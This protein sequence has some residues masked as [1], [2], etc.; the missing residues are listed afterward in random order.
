MRIGVAQTRPVK[1]DIRRNIAG[2][3]A[4]I[5]LAADYGADAIIFP[6]LSLTGYQPQLAKELAI[7]TDDLSLDEFQA[8]S[9]IMNITIGVGIPIRNSRGI[10]ISML[11][12]RPYSGVAVYSKKYLHPDEEPF[13]VPGDAGKPLND[14]KVAI[15]I[16]YELSVPQH[17]VDAVSNGAE[18]YIASVAKSAL[19]VES[20]V[21]ILAGIAN[22]YNMIVLMS[23][24]VGPCEGFEA[25]G[26][27]SVWN[28]KGVLLRQLN[29]SSEGILIVNTVTEDVTA[30]ELTQP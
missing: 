11:V 13:F 16:C 23:N 24:C 21:P 10:N 19:G 15:A 8:L 9:E 4:L 7:T 3:K 25:A 30:V 22:Q 29:D 6:E 26:R 20:A 17:L 27:S 18:I 14:D 28:R 1:G 2:H 12:F 5:R